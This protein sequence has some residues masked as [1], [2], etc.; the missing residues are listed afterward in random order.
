MPLLSVHL[1][2]FNNKHHLDDTLQSILM[3]EVDFDFE[4]VVGDDCSTDGTYELLQRYSKDHPKL[5]NI[6]QNANRLG[7]LKNYKTTLDRCKGAYIFD[8]AG[9][10]FLK[11]KYSLQ[12]MVNLFCQYPETGFIDSGYDRLNE[13]DSSYYN[14]SNKTMIKA[15]KEAYKKEL[16]LGKI[17]PI[18]HCFR[19]DKLYEHVD[20]KAYIDQGVGIED[21][22]ILVNMAMHTNFKRIDESLLVYRVHE[23]SYSHNKELDKII[24]RKEEMRA[25][26]DQF[27]KSYSF[28]GDLQKEYYLNHHKQLLFYAG[29][30]ENKELGK[31]SYKKISSKSFKDL[32]HYWASQNKFFRKLISLRK[33]FF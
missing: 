10:D 26:F 2:T 31:E 18:G 24:A 22:P 11:E 1:I 5:F 14:Y 7:I 4:I 20:F 6:Q 3:Q 9:D 19:R 33:K 30:F 8:I 21:Y 25:L 23:K 17:A 28:S 32:V 13:V 27:S 15:N 12:K 29:Y 16:L